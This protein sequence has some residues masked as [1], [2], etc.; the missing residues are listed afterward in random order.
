MAIISLEDI[1]S[2]KT[3]FFSTSLV[4]VV[5]KSNGREILTTT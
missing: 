4:P 3:Y 1:V 5:V 2:V